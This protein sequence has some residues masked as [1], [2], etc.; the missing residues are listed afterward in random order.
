MKHE[1]LM[2]TQMN[3]GL[4]IIIRAQEEPLQNLGMAIRV[5]WTY[6]PGGIK[7]SQALHYVNSEKALEPWKP[8]RTE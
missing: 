1:L 8:R 7:G 2:F 5:L 3:M 4:N 6:E